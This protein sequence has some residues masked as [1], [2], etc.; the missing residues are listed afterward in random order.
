MKRAMYYHF[1]A[2]VSN[3]GAHVRVCHVTAAS[4]I[5]NQRV[6]ITHIPI[7]DENFVANRFRP[8]FPKSVRKEVI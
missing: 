1:H 2:S 7:A 5:N 8:L 4:L 6:L 3:E